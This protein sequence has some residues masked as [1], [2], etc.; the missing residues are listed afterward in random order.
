MWTYDIL[1]SLDTCKN[2]FTS[3]ELRGMLRHVE[4]SL[5]DATAPIII[6]IRGARSNTIEQ[7]DSGALSF[8]LRCLF[9]DIKGLVTLSHLIK[10]VL[11]GNLVCLGDRGGHHF[12]ALVVE[13]ELAVVFFSVLFLLFGKDYALFNV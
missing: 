4:L 10:L 11:I 5:K 12:L 6:V 9:T 8:S 13:L 1:L 3:L 2:L 7:I